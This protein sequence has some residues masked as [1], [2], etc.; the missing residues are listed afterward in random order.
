M[1]GTVLAQEAQNEFVPAET[2]QR[3]E[4]PSGPLVYAAYAFAW[5]ALLVYVFMLWRKLGRV[6]RELGAL[7]Q[8]SAR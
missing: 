5:A 3:Q 8:K 4:L 1:I 6:E 2:L 7:R